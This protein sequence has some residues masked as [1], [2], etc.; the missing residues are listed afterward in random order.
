MRKKRIEENYRNTLSADGRF[1]PHISIKTSKRISAYCK[2]TNQNKTKFVE[3]CCNERLD[4]LETETEY[5]V[6]LPKEDLISII[7]SH[8]G[9]AT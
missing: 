2:F 6:S 4:V 7:Q 1:S 3:K 8:I 9:G 5:L